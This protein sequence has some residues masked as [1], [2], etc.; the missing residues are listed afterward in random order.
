MK[1]SDIVTNSYTAANNPETENLVQATPEELLHI[2]RKETVLELYPG[3]VVTEDPVLDAENMRLIVKL[4][5][6]HFDKDCHGC[7]QHGYSRKE[8]PELCRGADGVY[9]FIQY[10]LYKDNIKLFTVFIK[11]KIFNSVFIHPLF[12][13]RIFFICTI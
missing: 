10:L 3:C 1:P 8:V 11:V 7:E 4:A 9:L 5:Y 12:F 2:R 6:T 13:I